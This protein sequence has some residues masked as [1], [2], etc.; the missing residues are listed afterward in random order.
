MSKIIVRRQEYANNGTH[1]NEIEA[2]VQQ[3]LIA[4]TLSSATD[5]AASV[6]LV[7]SETDGIK[8]SLTTLSDPPNDGFTLLVSNTTLVGGFCSR[9]GRI[10]VF[11]IVFTATGSAQIASG[12]NIVEFPYH[13]ATRCDF[14]L[15]SLEG[16]VMS[17]LYLARGSSRG[18]VNGTALAAND[19]TYFASGAFLT[20][21]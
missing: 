4:N 2:V 20:N 3:N 9:V 14:Q 11:N 12:T 18:A 16:A 1:A 5:I 21:D 7:K 19:K 13:N 17:D 10:V 15:R 6:G 8:E